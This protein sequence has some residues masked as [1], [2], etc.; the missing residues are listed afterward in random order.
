MVRDT[1]V[2]ALKELYQMETFCT[3]RM[4]APGAAAGGLSWLRAARSGSLV[5]PAMSCS[6]CSTKIPARPSAGAF[7]F[8]YEHLVK[9]RTR[10]AG[11]S[12]SQAADARGSSITGHPVTCPQNWPRPGSVQSNVI[13]KMNDVMAFSAFI[14][15]L[16]RTPEPIIP[17]RVPNGPA[18]SRIRSDLFA[19]RAIVSTLYLIQGVTLLSCHHNCCHSRRCDDATS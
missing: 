6:C 17:D 14:W 4:T 5:W 3:S 9:R 11:Q 8:L 1:S 15:A 7:R 18:Y 16:V 19:S 2:T 12:A 10:A 13:F